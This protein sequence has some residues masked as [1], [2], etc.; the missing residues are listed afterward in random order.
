[1]TGIPDLFTY[2]LSEQT[3]HSVRHVGIVNWDLIGHN[4]E[5]FL[6]LV[7]DEGTAEFLRVGGNTT[8][9]IRTFNIKLD[10]I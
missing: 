3:S 9:D 7:R 5:L 1:M 8:E 6:I 10:R 4:H 2:V